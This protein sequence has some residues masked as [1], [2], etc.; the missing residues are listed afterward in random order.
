MKITIQNK[1]IS[2]EFLQVP[3]FNFGQ[4]QRW[5]NHE[6]ITYQLEIETSAFITLI[7]AYFNEFRA[8]EIEDDD[9]LGLEELIAYKNLGF[10]TLTEML[11]NHKEI[12][13][14]VLIFNAYEILHLLFKEQLS[15]KE[16]YFYSVNSIDAIHF[17]KSNVLLTGI[18]F[19]VKRN[20]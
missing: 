17:K 14:D 19:L 12:L 9:V 2:K 15:A 13:C 1:P 6:Q 7:E 11:T 8:T 16:K 20:Q 3:E 10:P 4:F 18:C 5:K